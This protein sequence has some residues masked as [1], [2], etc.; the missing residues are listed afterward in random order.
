MLPSPPTAGDGNI[1]VVTANDG[2][3]S[4]VFWGDGSGDVFTESAATLN[5]VINDRSVVHSAH[6][7][8]SD[9]KI[10][11]DDLKGHTTLELFDYDGDGVLDVL[12]GPFVLKSNG[13]RTFTSDQEPGF[14]ETKCVYTVDMGASWVCTEPNAISIGDYDNDGDMVRT[15]PIF[16]ILERSHR[17]SLTPL[18]A[19]VLGAGFPCSPSAAHPTIFSL[20]G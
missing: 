1:D 11:D 5:S 10:V 7:A 16:A 12:L 9:V 13:D 4:Q 2:E 14:T 19:L 8:D 18:S 15:Q 3:D 17:N 6:G 20:R